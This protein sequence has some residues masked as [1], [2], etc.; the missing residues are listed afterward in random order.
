MP[1]AG[2]S[3]LK[4]F[5]KN[6]MPCVGS[7]CAPEPKQ[8]LLSHKSSVSVRREIAVPLIHMGLALP[9]KIERRWHG[10]VVATIAPAPNV[11]KTDHS[12]QSYQFEYHND[13]R[14]APLKTNNAILVAQSGEQQDVQM[15]RAQVIGLVKNHTSRLCLSGFLLLLTKL[16]ILTYAANLPCFMSADGK[17]LNL[18]LTQVR[19]ILQLTIRPWIQE[20]ISYPVAPWIHQQRVIRC[21]AQ[22]LHK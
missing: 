13:I 5:A 16:W 6:T 8:T 3:K 22:L 14:V 17:I 12:S 19:I 10:C 18:C 9:L 1:S 11:S 21:P 20:N 15:T 2:S 7:S 4:C